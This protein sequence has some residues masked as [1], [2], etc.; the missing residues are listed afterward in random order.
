MFGIVIDDEPWAGATTL[1]AYELQL[2]ARRGLGADPSR[3]RCDA[4]PARD[5]DHYYPIKQ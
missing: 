4:G 3:G 2:P 5:G 1:R